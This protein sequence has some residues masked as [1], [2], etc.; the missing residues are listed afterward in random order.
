MPS[1]Y[2]KPSRGLSGAVCFVKR[3]NFAGLGLLK[4]VYIE[5]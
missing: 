4:L 1:H 3:L 2:S 5:Q